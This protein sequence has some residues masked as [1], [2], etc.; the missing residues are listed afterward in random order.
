MSSNSQNMTLEQK[1]VEQIKRY[2]LHELLDD[3][4]AIAELA[5]RAV[6]EALIQPRRAL[7]DGYGRY[8]EQDAP[9]VAA[10]RDLAKQLADDVAAKL[11]ADA[12]FQKLLRDAM[13]DALPN[14]ISNSL[15]GVVTM[16]QH[17]T[18]LL[19]LDKVREHVRSGLPM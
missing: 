19:A 1:I 11:A 13:A 7:G 15:A 5:K 17:Q 3:E 4:D 2:G 8:T 10:A 9:V 6:K 18:A 16:L 12:E 14:A